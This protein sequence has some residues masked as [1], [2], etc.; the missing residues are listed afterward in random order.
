MRNENESRLVEESRNKDFHCFSF[1]LVSLI[2]F[3]GLIIP[4]LNK[5]YNFDF[6]IKL[7][8]GIIKALS[9]FSTVLVM[10]LA[11]GLGAGIAAAFIRTGIKRSQASCV[12]DSQN[13]EYR[14]T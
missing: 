2:A 5:K 1:K 6:G 14:G 9:L 13:H 7:D 3:V 11:A 10:S 8:N 12:G 4:C